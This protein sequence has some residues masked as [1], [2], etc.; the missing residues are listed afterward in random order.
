VSEAKQQVFNNRSVHDEA[1]RVFT[2]PTTTTL[3]FGYKLQLRLVNRLRRRHI[4]GST[5]FSFVCRIEAIRSGDYIKRYDNRKDNIIM[6]VCNV[7]LFTVIR[8]S[9]SIKTLEQYYN[10][11]TRRVISR[12]ECAT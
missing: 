5:S 4:K 3:L 7:I 6:S 8:L 1:V 11:H 9:F 2:Y 12:L 10:T